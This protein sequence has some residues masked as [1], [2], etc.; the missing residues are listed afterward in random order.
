MNAPFVH[1][2]KIRFSHCDP[3]G[4]LY[5][6]LAFDLLNAAVEDWFETELGMPSGEFHMRHRV[7][8]VRGR[9][10]AV[11]GRGRAQWWVAPAW[12]RAVAAGANHRC[13]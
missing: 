6:P 2:R 12:V 13:A 5:F 8:A 9:G 10:N 7:G 1:Q 3:A 4:I 11:A